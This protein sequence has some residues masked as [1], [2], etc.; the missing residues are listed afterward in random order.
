MVNKNGQKMH[1]TCVLKKNSGTRLK[2][3]K[4]KEKNPL[5]KMVQK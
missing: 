3:F 5:N 2:F 4:K 1:L